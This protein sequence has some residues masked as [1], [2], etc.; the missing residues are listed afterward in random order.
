MIPRA[1]ANLRRAFFSRFEPAKPST[2]DPSEGRTGIPFPE[3]LNAAL[4]TSRRTPHLHTAN[5]AYELQLDPRPMSTHTVNSRRNQ[6]SY[7]ESWVNMMVVRNGR[8]AQEQTRQ[9]QC[10]C[11]HLDPRGFPSSY[12]GGWD[13]SRKKQSIEVLVNLMMPSCRYLEGCCMSKSPSGPATA[14]DT[15]LALCLTAQQQFQLI[16]SL[17]L[18]YGVLEHLTRLGWAIGSRRVTIALRLVTS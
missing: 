11:L 16:P 7:A 5:G 12:S 9:H 18:R 17:N 8:R 6:R 1:S 3:T 15:C 13:L 10:S 4:C 2:S 14:G